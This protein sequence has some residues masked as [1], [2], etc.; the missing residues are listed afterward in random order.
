MFGYRVLT[1]PDPADTDEDDPNYNQSR[2][3]VTKR[4]RYVVSVCERFWK[5]WKTE[6]LQ[7][8]RVSHRIQLQ[9]SNKQHVNP[10]GEGKIV[11]VFEEGTPRHS[12]R[13]V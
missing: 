1:L 7:E 6:Y 11:I 3:S 5:R 9:R 2:E 10:I 13:L 12:W 8:L 4:M